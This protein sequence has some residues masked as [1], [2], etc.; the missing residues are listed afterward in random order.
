MCTKKSGAGIV[1]DKGVG[2]AHKLVTFASSIVEFVSLAILLLITTMAA[3]AAPF[4]YVGNSY[5]DSV[6]VIDTATNTV[7]DTVVGVDYPAGIAIAP[8]GA[9]AYIVGSDSN[10]VSVI[11]TATNAIVQ[12]VVVGSLPDGIAITP[13][14]AYVYTANWLS[15]DVSVIDTATNSVVQTVAVGNGP[16]KIAITPHKPIFS[17]G[18]RNDSE[19]STTRSNLNVG[20]GTFEMEQ[21]VADD[22]TLASTSVIQ[23]LGWE[24]SYFQTALPANK[25]SVAFRIQFYTSLAGAPFLEM[26]VNA[27]YR[28]VGTSEYGSPIYRFTA[29]LGDESNALILGSGTQFWVAIAESDPE[30]STDFRWWKVGGV[31]PG[32]F[33]FRFGPASPWRFF[34][35]DGGYNPWDFTFDLFGVVLPDDVTAPEIQAD[36]SGVLGNAGWYVSDVNVAWLLTDGQ[37]SIISKSGCDESQVTGD[38]VG[39]T[40][41]CTATSAGGTTTESVTI[42]RDATP[43]TAAASAGPP[44]NQYG[45]NKQNVT[46]TFSGTD[47]LSGSVTCDPQVVLSSEGADQTASGRCYDAAGNQSEL[48]TV[49]GINIDK[50]APTISIASPIN[51]AV[52]SLNQSVTASYSCNDALS[53]VVDCSG[54]VDD[55]AQIN[56]SKKTKNAKFIVTATDSAGNTVKQ[57]V[58]Y[59]VK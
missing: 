48:A 14:G 22:F 58:T 52:Y 7:V 17:Q 16:Y 25:T 19:S 31:E 57:T 36:V 55:G 30:T 56:T 10:S 28:Q 27:V 39:L 32:V 9:Y 29:K 15:Q 45:W 20:P 42:K 12:T 6:S 35:G 26:E 34:G 23:K 5:S 54:S 40:L 37:S 2:T 44:A 47:D 59:T 8:D 38:T 3:Q 21:E 49:T 11:D 46:V 24:G 53:G 13:D 4:A 18:P 51:G 43:P 1:A 41:T 33:A 50:T